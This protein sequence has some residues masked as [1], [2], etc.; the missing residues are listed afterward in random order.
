MPAR[1]A[2]RGCDGWSDHHG[3]RAVASERSPVGGAA[4]EAGR[5]GTVHAHNGR[6]YAAPTQDL[7]VLRLSVPSRLVIV[8]C[9]LVSAGLVLGTPRSWPLWVTTVVALIPWLPTF[10]AGARWNYRRHH[11][12][13]KLRLKPSSPEKGTASPRAASL[14]AQAPPLA[15][16]VTALRVPS[17]PRPP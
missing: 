14:L 5:Q 4:T 9:A 3:P 15:A 10:V 6:W 17:S 11:W 1:R 7:S 16:L 13:V 8:S 12:V 2:P